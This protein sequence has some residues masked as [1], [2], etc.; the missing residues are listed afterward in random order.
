MAIQKQSDEEAKQAAINRGVELE[1]F[2]KT[3]S[4]QI[5]VDWLS[6]LTEEALKD[7]RRSNT[8]DM[9]KQVDDRYKANLQMKWTLLE[10]IS[11][12]FEYLVQD[13][14]LEKNRLIIEGNNVE[15]Q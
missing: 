6:G 11:R 3:P 7:I 5:V 8:L 12:E 14:V 15:S 9:D 4:Y 13:A 10:H 2:F 1:S